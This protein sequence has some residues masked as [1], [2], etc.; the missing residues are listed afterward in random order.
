MHWKWFV[1]DKGEMFNLRICFLLLEIAAIDE[2]F[3]R[4]EVDAEKKH[5]GNLLL[6]P[7][8]PSWL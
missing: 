4:F 7:W 8:S 5:P 3:V 1:D 6:M 2:P